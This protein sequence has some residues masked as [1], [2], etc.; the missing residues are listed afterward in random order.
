MKRLKLNVKQPRIISFLGRLT[1]INIIASILIGYR[2]FISHLEKMDLS[3]FIFSNSALAST[4]VINYLVV[5]G[6]LFLAVHRIKKVR[7]IF[8]ISILTFAGVQVFFLLDSTF[9]LKLGLHLYAML[10]Y[11]FNFL[12]QG[13]LEIG[14]EFIPLFIIGLL[15]FIGFEYYF[16]RLVMPFWGKVGLFKKQLPS[17]WKL[18]LVL[19]AS[20]AFVSEKYIFI[21]AQI[22]N[23]KAIKRY[24]LAIPFY[25]RSLAR[26][27]PS[28]PINKEAQSHSAL[29]YPLR[30]LSGSDDRYNLIWVTVEGLNTQERE[31]NKLPE[32]EKISEQCIDFQN[33][34]SVSSNPNRNLFSAYYGLF[35]PYYPHFQKESRTPLLFERLQEDEYELKAFLPNR[36]SRS[37]LKKL[38]F[39]E[40]EHSLETEDK[41]QANQTVLQYFKSWLVTRDSNAPFAMFLHFD[42][43]QFPYTFDLK[44]IKYFP[45]INEPN[46]AFPKEPNEKIYN[47]YR[48]ALA[49]Q[50]EILGELWAFIKQNIWSKHTVVVI[51]SNGLDDS[52][53][54]WSGMSHDKLRVPFLLYIPSEEGKAEHRSLQSVDIAPI[55]ANAMGYDTKEKYYTNGKNLLAEASRTYFAFWFNDSVSV[56]NDLSLKDPKKNNTGSIEGQI[57]WLEEELVKFKSEK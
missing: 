39:I 21:K 37:E 8:Q 5:F 41:L 42:V 48:N 49:Y 18:T 24:A 10:N 19:L 40:I 17:K 47:A 33:C 23:N 29:N 32:L 36:L 30:S 25:P 14:G 27:I 6:L 55:V 54:K 50:D 57:N 46:F 1:L 35:P 3:D 44:K 26:L 43:A 45:F 12:Q 51:T 9:Y 38:M 16:G 28:K 34:Y 7:R 31:K 22:Y 11:D 13:F 20:L 53:A 2:N 52:I 56:L 15:V 4:M